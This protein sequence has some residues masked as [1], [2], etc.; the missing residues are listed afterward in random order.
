MNPLQKNHHLTLDITALSADGQGLGEAKGRPILVNGALP[1]ERVAVKV[2]KVTA[3]HAVARL[4]EVLTA[5]PDR[6][7][8]FCNVFG[9]C[10]GCTLQHLAYAAQCRLKTERLRE[11]LAGIPT[12]APLR[13]LAG[14]DAGAPTDSGAPALVHGIIG[15]NAPRRYRHKA[16]Y[17]VAFARNAARMG[18]YARHSHQIIEHADCDVQPPVMTRI[19]DVARDFLNARRISIYDETTQRG[20]ARHLLIRC[21]KATGECVV[22]LVLN[23]DRLPHGDEFAAALTHQVPAVTGIVLNRNIH[24]TNRILGPD[25]ETLWGSATLV[26][27]LGDQWFEMS[28]QSF[29]QVNPQQTELLYEYVERYAGLTGSEQV[30]DLYCGIGTIALRLAR[31]AGRVHG[32]DSVPQ[33]IQDAGRNARRNHIANAEFTT[34]AAERVFP[35]M[36]RQ[37]RSADVVI[38]DPPRK[39]CDRALIEAVAGCDPGRV[40]YVSCHPDS[41]IRDLAIFEQ[42]GFCC[43][44]IQPVDLFPHTMHVECVARIDPRT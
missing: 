19:R 43:T 3:R 8:P 15:M 16:Q 20:L 40:V 2:I 11:Q 39:G 36:I 41:L 32:I 7:R 14:R 28:P 31:R 34:G 38:L 1:G 21:A 37:G 5:S 35:A 30:F 24:A 23:G 4:N 25:D 27:R 12:G 22:T 10:G 18:L 29:Y 26:D 13:Q 42:F 33:A 6:V 17:P 9:R 44:A